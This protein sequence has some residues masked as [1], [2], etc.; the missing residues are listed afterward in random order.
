MTL[1]CIGL[2][3]RPRLCVS[4]GI[5]DT[6]EGEPFAALRADS[7]L[8]LLGDAPLRNQLS[9][10]RRAHFNHRHLLSYYIPNIL[11]TRISRPP[12]FA[13]GHS[14]IAERS[15][16]RRAAPCQYRATN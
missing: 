3:L 13:E 10:A 2:L 1:L 9:R 16:A 4:A 12:K 14:S 7:K 8:D 5:R 6:A 11:G 15:G